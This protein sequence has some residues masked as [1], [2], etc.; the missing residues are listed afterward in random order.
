M[1][2][3]SWT[4]LKA[5]EASVIIM[6]REGGTRRIYVPHRRRMGLSAQAPLMRMRND[7][8]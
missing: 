8:R 5:I 4:N 3:R 2:K 6:R 1:R 7:R